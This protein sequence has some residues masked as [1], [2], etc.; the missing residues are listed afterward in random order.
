MTI[1]TLGYIQFKTHS[2]AISKDSDDHR[3]YCF[4]S[5]RN[6]CD[7]ESFDDEESAAEFILTPFPTVVYEL[8][9]PG[10]NQ[11]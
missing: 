1:R 5:T 8:K 7:L 2:V 11:T 9:M 4:K 6:R 10:E 3:I